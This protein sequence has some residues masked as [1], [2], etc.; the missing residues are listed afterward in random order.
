MRLQ[1][2]NDNMVI[3]NKRLFSKTG[4]IGPATIGSEEW[5]RAKEKQE[6]MQNF[7]RSIKPS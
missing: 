7:L 4:G 6:R 1:T 3:S 2:P 5:M